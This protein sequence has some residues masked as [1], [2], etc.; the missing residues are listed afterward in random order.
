MEKRLKKSKLITQKEH[1]EWHRKNKEYNNKIDKERELCHKKI[2]LT[3][4]KG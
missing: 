3:V 2:G 1:D 4:K